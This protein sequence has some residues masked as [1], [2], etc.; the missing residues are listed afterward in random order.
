M[1][2]FIVRPSV[3][4]DLDGKT[5]QLSPYH[6]PLLRHIETIQSHLRDE[7][8]LIQFVREGLAESYKRGISQKKYFTIYLMVT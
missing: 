8:L 6:K 5:F 3:G 2:P 7:S 1:F 4:V